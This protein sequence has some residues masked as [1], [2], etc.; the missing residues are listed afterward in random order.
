MTVL[1]ISKPDEIDQNHLNF[2]DEEQG[3]ITRLAMAES[4]DEVR[5]IAKTCR[6]ITEVR[7]DDLDKL[8]DLQKQV[9]RTWHTFI[10]AGISYTNNITTAMELHREEIDEV[11]FYG[12]KF[13]DHYRETKNATLYNWDDICQEELAKILD[14]DMPKALKEILLKELLDQCPNGGIS[15]NKVL[16]EA[17]KIFFKMDQKVPD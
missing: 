14:K 7:I 5:Q 6:K 4:L 1:E 13:P 8:D 2:K 10:L 11:G 17:G 16:I 15:Y 3:I 9:L 12:D